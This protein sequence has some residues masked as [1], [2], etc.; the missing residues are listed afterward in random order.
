[1]K[2]V[3]LV[4]LIVSFSMIAALNNFSFANNTFQMGLLVFTELSSTELTET[5]NGNTF[6]LSNIADNEWSWPIPTYSGTLIGPVGVPGINWKEPEDPNLYN[7]LRPPSGSTI[8]IV[9]DT[10]TKTGSV[11]VDDGFVANDS[12]Y[13][14]YW[15]DQGQQLVRAD[16]YSV[17]FIDKGDAPSAVPE[18][19]TMLLLG[20]GL[21]GL[22]GY[23][24]KKFFKE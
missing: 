22:A 8:H 21:I 15:D 14:E 5:F 4:A 18:P 2:K 13:I 16:V 24:R 9:S 10:S 1:M 23:G 19:A 17:Q 11:V 7:T 3:F 20:S 6:T 12:L